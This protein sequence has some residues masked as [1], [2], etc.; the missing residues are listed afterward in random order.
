MPTFTPVVEEIHSPWVEL[1]RVSSRTAVPI[2]RDSGLPQLRN[3]RVL[4][5]KLHVLPIPDDGQDR[6]IR[7][8]YFRRDLDPSGEHDLENG[9][10]KHFPDL[11]I[12]EVGM[13][14]AQDLEDASALRYFTAMREAAR[15]AY[16][17]K[18]EEEEHAAQVLSY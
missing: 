8:F 5:N 11:F 12:A 17:D 9:W 3:F 1:K 14:L 6:A 13:R 18:V 15:K 2:E 7:L 16:D 4:G 10:M